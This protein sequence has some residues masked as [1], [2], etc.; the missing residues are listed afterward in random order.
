MYQGSRRSAS[1]VAV[2]ET[3][4]IVIT[5]AD[6]G[7]PGW[8]DSVA[9]LPGLRPFRVR[10]SDR[11]AVR[12]STGSLGVCFVARAGHTYTVRPVYA[13]GTWR[14]EIIDQNTTERVRTEGF[15]DKDGLD[16]CPDDEERYVQGRRLIIIPVPVH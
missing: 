1:E 16:L 11:P 4:G 15:G 3:D 10:L 2:V 12:S 8:Y 5:Q 14:P 13:Q 9:V 7:E 6:Q